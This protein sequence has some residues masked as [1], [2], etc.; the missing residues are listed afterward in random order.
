[1]IEGLNTTDACCNEARTAR[2]QKVKNEELQQRLIEERLRKDTCDKTYIETIDFKPLN[3]PKQQ[4]VINACARS[5]NVLKMLEKSGNLD[6]I[7][8]AIIVAMKSRFL[9]LLNKKVTR[10]KRGISVAKYV[11]SD[12]EA[13]FLDAH[14]RI[15]PREIREFFKPWLAKHIVETTLERE[16][17]LSTGMVTIKF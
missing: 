5:G 17:I 10:L 9:I 4:H 15:I 6:L 3:I 13:E 16:E 14:T 7:T 11:Y 8:E 2:E 12:E 1:M